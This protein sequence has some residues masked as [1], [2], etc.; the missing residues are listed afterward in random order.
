M[1]SLTTTKKARLLSGA[2]IIA[3]GLYYSNA[4]AETIN[5]H[6][7]FNTPVTA[8]N[9]TTG[10]INITPGASVTTQFGGNHA[11]QPYRAGIG[12][13]TVNVDG[14]V[15]VLDV[16]NEV[17]GIWLRG[18]GN[19]TVSANGSVEGS[20]KGI[21]IDNGLA[22]VVNHGLVS[23]SQIA[24]HI[25]NGG[26]VLNDGRMLGG[27]VFAS[28]ATAGTLTNNG[29]ISADFY[30]G[31]GVIMNKGG[32]FINRGSASFRDIGQGFL[33]IG[34]VTLNNSGTLRAEAADSN[35]NQTSGA[36]FRSG[37][38]QVSNSGLIE[39]RDLGMFF[40]QGTADLTNSG[41]IK[42]LRL[43]AVNMAT[44]GAS[45]F[46][47]TGGSTLGGRHG[48]SITTSAST[49]VSVK[50]G[51]VTGGLYRNDG[52]G[53]RIAGGGATSATIS[54]ATV[55]GVAAAIQGGSGNFDL[56]L[57]YGSRVYGLVDLGTGT[58]SL[59]MSTDAI[60]QGDIRGGSGFSS[61]ELNGS[62]HG[63]FAGSFSGFESAVVTNGTWVLGGN[64]TFVNGITVASGS[65]IVNG[66]IVGGV[67]VNSGGYLGGS[68]STGSMTFANGSIIAPGNS[69]GTLTVA[70]D[71]NLAAGAV[72]RVEVDPSSTAS[73]LIAVSG[74]ANLNGAT[75]RHIGYPG[76][77]NPA[78]TYTILK[79]GNIVG[80]FGGVTSD[81]AFLDPVLGYSAN[82][83]TMSLARNDVS[84]A[85]VAQTTNQRVTS[86][87]LAQLGSG[88]IVND[89]LV[90][91]DATGARQAYDLLS[92]EIY[93]TAKTVLTEDSRFVRDAINDRLYGSLADTGAEH[94]A[95]WGQGFG[96]RGHSDGDGNAARFGRST[97]G[98]LL[99]GDIAIFEGWRF[100]AVAGYS[101]TSFDAAARA[102][103][104]SSDNYHVGLYGGTQWGDFTFRTGAA[105]TWHAL[106]T[107]RRIAFGGFNERAKGSYD[108]GTTQVFGEVGYRVETGL[109]RFEPFAHLA[110]VNVNT[111]SFQE[112]GG[113][114]GLSGGG[115][116]ADTTFTTLGLRASS[117]FDLDGA[118]VSARGLI[119]LQH[120]FTDAQPTS[121]QA[122]Q[123][124]SS[125]AV[126]GVPIAQ[127]TAILQA[128]IDV[129][130]SPEATLGLSYAAQIASDTV[131]QSLKASFKVNF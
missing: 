50:G 58:S 94:A 37:D 77:Y 15:K 96:S 28:T 17:F 102:S 54:N 76:V 56:A 55:R 74:V 84:F 103:L 31:F 42:G 117:T 73:D 39:G 81:F 72:Y 25:L 21:V 62:G 87:A 109:A 47:Q 59:K 67:T 90:G 7:S 121:A 26:T 118:I 48:I 115:G 91:L 123:G 24:T 104:S 82:A 6:G 80:T 108:A 38:I 16:D 40:Y 43:D 34:N 125:F 53:I 95:V 69:I 23:G 12:A 120:A 110:H 83:V 85:D 61:L 100:G 8:V 98:L 79:A 131:D 3:I 130:L 88:N 129:A 101:Q 4:V 45:A 18:G 36:L 105:Y 19:V 29:T 32:S 11:I 60:V 111:D 46:E 57:L 52:I 92:G 126:A 114:A 13:W 116:S 65:L 107:D 127:N 119:G 41:T 30:N 112:M 78:S 27:V 33:S 64:S 106:T 75:V 2:S 128:G 97:G 86:S 44:A 63:N 20:R 5:L 35:A 124:S 22:H 122:I 14:R 93:A 71:L 68:G 66:S 10:F 49:S 99:G 9:D 89:V 113:A 70:G 51:E 1:P